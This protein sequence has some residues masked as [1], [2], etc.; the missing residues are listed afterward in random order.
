MISRRDAAAVALLVLLVSAAFAGAFRHG[1]SDVDD[2]QY[3]TENRHVRKGLT[4]HGIAWAFG[5]IE[6]ANWH[7]LTW[8]SHMTD[9]SAFG[10]RPAGHH[11][12]SVA[13][14]AASAG[15]LYLAL[16]AMTGRRA[17][18][19][20]AAGIFG[21]HPLRVESV[22]WIAERKDVL[23][24]LF[25]MATLLA[26]ASYARRPG[27]T[28]LSLVFGLFV[29]GLLAK[30]MLV[31]LP[32]A[33]LLLDAWPLG[34]LARFAD[35]R[36]LLGEK[37]PLFGAAA[38]SSAATYYAQSHGH[39]V[40]S[41]QVLPLQT[42]IANAI[43]TCVVYLQQEIWPAGLAFFYPHA[44]YTGAA[45][46]APARVAFAVV[47]LAAITALAWLLRR[48]R[49][50]VAVG[51]L[52]YLGMLVPVVGVVQVGEQ[53]HADRYTYLP[54]IGP[55]VAAVWAIDDRARRLPA[56]GVRFAAG[57]GAAL[58]IVLA[59]LTR[60]QV[61]IWGDL[62]TLY[63]HAL[64]TTERNF[65]AHNNLGV[66]L[67]KAGRPDEAEAHFEES[68][69]AYPEYSEGQDNL[70]TSLMK[71][72][73]IAESLEHFE[74]ALL[75]GSVDPK[76]HNNLGNALIGSG[77]IEAGIEELEE[78]LRLDPDYATAHYN[79]AMVLGRIG[80][81]DLAMAQFDAAVRLGPERA[82]AWAN[83]GLLRATMGR[84]RDAAADYREALKRR[85]DWP[86][87]RRALAL[88]EE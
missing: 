41:L 49:P 33:L 29:L 68:I 10:L 5:S 3:V 59:T 15:L 72:G 62:R 23:S 75:W 48:G 84:K 73:R 43:V 57:A 13:L 32:F 82:E 52:W 77:S 42:R 31:T 74:T 64:A 54:L 45:D 85:P 80:R 56:A 26:Y 35:L 6:A 71:R 60:A 9:V 27:R 14:H 67:A 19:F 11:A 39:A 30:P 81:S 12:T 22:V 66:V 53:A 36:G 78:A 47:V 25:A 7:P 55:V 69:R 18:S 28:R 63:E 34:R 51:W 20:F 16:S 4:L 70:G 21:L 38:V 17:P 2:P 1:F 79:L 37:A 44:G 58:L 8:I 24:T 46:Y 88:A 83:R 65:V 86:D 40:V 50:Y 61:A 87:V 76:I